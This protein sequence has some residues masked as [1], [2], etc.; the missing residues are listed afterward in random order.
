MSI[1]R[2]ESRTREVK[3]VFRNIY[4]LGFVS[5][6][7]DISSEM[8][9]S[10]L[11]AFILEL[12]GTGTAM[13][14]IIE[15]VP[16]ALSYSLRAISGVFSDKL[17]KRRIIVFIGY[18]FSTGIKPFFAAAQTAYDVLVIRVSDRVGKAIRTA[19]RDALVAKSVTEERRG[20]AFGHI[21]P[22][23]RQEQ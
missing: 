2:K 7:T 11:P 5:L 1:K 19:P 17:R 9:F 3:G 6:F 22:W 23:T 10:I 8:A 15:G 12:P 13:L 4:F 16:E 20:A 21:E 14:E 18:A